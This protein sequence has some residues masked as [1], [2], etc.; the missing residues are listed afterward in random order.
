MIVFSLFF[1]YA[2]GS[3]ARQQEMYSATT[4][5]IVLEEWKPLEKQEFVNKC[6]FAYIHLTQDIL[7][8]KNIY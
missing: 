5:D 2:W 1:N 3:E 8:N 4:E 6:T 7:K